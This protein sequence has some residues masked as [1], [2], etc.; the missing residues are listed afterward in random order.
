MCL[1][2]YT[3]VTVIIDGGASQQEGN[4]MGKYIVAI[5]GQL[6]L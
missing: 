5:I 1:Y 3:F 6:A 2:G 4:A